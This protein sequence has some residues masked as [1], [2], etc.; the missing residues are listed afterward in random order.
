MHFILITVMGRGEAF[1]QNG[2]P[3]IATGHI[4]KVIH[5]EN[6]CNYI[7]GFSELFFIQKI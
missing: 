6:H 7:V 4:K 3:A 2:Y 5:F 1:Q